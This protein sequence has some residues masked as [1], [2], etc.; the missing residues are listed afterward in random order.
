MVTLFIFCDLIHLGVLV[1]LFFI[2][3]FFLCRQKIAK[4]GELNYD[5]LITGPSYFTHF[6]D[7]DKIFEL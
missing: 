6:D 4:P 2:D 5:C 7:E 1:Y 3:F